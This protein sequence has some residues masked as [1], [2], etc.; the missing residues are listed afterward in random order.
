[1]RV[2]ARS[3]GR[4]L[5]DAEIQADEDV[6]IEGV[7]RLRPGLSVEVLGEANPEGAGP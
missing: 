6:V 7:Q 1:V 5:L 4:V 3:Q 2:V